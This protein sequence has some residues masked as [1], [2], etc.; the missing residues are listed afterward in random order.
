MNCKQVHAFDYFGVLLSVIVPRYLHVKTRITGY[1]VRRN[2][3]S[4]HRPLDEVRA[5]Y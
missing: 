4:Y 2:Y 1:N 3:F 5:L